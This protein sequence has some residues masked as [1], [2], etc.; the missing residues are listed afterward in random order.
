MDVEMRIV[1]TLRLMT[2]ELTYTH[3]LGHQDEAATTPPTPLTREALLN[4]E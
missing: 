4:V 1:D 2:L 3:V